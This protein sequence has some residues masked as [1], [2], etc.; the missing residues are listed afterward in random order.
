MISESETFFVVKTK[1]VT[2]DEESKCLPSIHPSRPSTQQQ[3]KELLMIL[4]RVVLLEGLG[5]IVS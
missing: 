4:L 2:L 3:T 1:F 5:T